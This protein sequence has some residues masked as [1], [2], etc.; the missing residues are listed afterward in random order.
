MCMQQQ[1]LALAYGS[2]MALT[3]AGTYV[4]GKDSWMAYLLLIPGFLILKAMRAPY[5]ESG[6]SKVRAEGSRGSSDRASGRRLRDVKRVARI[7]F[8][9][10]MLSI[11]A[12]LLAEALELNDSTI[13]LVL[14]PV[15]FLVSLV[16]REF[17]GWADSDDRRAGHSAVD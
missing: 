8:A 10:V 14:L 15:L 17:F 6:N 2:L 5:D 11:P 16:D 4:L 1:I 9:L 7:G 3:F 13:W 12:A